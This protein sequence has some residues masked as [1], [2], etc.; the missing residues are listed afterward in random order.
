[1]PDS[2][3]AKHFTFITLDDMKKMRHNVISL[4]VFI[5]LNCLGQFREI[6]CNQTTDVHGGSTLI[7]RVKKW[8]WR[9]ITCRWRH[10]NQ[11]NTITS[12]IAAKQTA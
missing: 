7:T 12:V 8:R 1:M 11:V 5:K 9:D 6:L 2:N 4:Y 10:R 3:F